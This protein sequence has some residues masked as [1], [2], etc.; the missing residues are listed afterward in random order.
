MTLKLR[1][2]RL[3]RIS[4][5]RFRSGWSRGCSVAVRIISREG[6]GGLRFERRFRGKKT[7]ARGGGG[8]KVSKFSPSGIGGLSTGRVLGHMNPKVILAKMMVKP[9]GVA[10]STV[11]NTGC[12][13]DLV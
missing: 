8:L 5:A 4:V 2:D 12:K 9:N 1:E 10:A 3:P 11:V 7:V 6:G 13:C